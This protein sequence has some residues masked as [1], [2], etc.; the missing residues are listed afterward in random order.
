MDDAEPD[1]PVALDPNA[2]TPE[3]L[4]A[5]ISQWLVEPPAGRAKPATESS[6]RPEG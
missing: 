1:E 6:P 5:V 2:V 4:A 3:Q